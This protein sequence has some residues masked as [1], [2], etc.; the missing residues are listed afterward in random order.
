MAPMFLILAVISL[1]ILVV[2]SLT[3]SALAVYILIARNQLA[4]KDVNNKLL[5]SLVTALIASLLSGLFTILHATLAWKSIHSPDYT[6]GLECGQEKL[7]GSSETTHVPCGIYKAVAAI[8]SSLLFV[9]MVIGSHMKAH[10]RPYAASLLGIRSGSSTRPTNG[11]SDNIQSSSR[12]TLLVNQLN[13]GPVAGSDGVSYELA[14]MANPQTTSH[15]RSRRQQ[16]LELP[17]PV[18]QAHLPNR[19]GIYQIAKNIIEG[20]C[21]GRQPEPHSSGQIIYMSTHLWV[22][23]AKSVLGPNAETMIYVTASSR[24]EAPSHFHMAH[25][26]HHGQRV[27][28]F[29]G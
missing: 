3:E 29:L 9:S 14:G 19:K 17:R 10:R 26:L 25:K 24:D 22:P 7:Q 28:T 5:A 6:L 12:D 4:T 2:A 11:S 21:Q 16:R 1:Y 23:A 27:S 13:Q 20:A 18:P 15:G 8:S